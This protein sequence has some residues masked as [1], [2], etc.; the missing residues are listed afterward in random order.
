MRTVR[1]IH[2]SGLVILL[3]EMK[4][5]S[6]ATLHKRRV[7]FGKKLHRLVVVELRHQPAL[8]KL[9]ADGSAPLELIH[10]DIIGESV[11]ADG[12]LSERRSDNYDK[13]RRRDDPATPYVSY[14]VG[15]HHDLCLPTETVSIVTPRH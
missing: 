9:N 7:A 11:Q 13:R 8:G 3:L 6:R 12:I 4:S 10:S 2:R 5:G 14:A 15:I 1:D